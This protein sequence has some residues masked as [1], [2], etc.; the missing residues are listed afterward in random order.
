MRTGA[1]VGIALDG[2]GDR[3]MIV[4][5]R[6]ELFDGDDV[7]ALLGVRMAAEGRLKANTVVATVMSN[8]GLERRP[9]AA[10]MRLVRTEVGDPAVVRE[11]RAQFLQ[12]RRRAVRPRHLHGPFD[13]RRRPDYGPD[14]ARRSWPRPASR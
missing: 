4:D 14:G 5:E 8:F 2:D 9:R 1:D 7:M 10:G 11:M 3:A 6:G 13:H 12:S